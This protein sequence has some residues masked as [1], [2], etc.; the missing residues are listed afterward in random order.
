MSSSITEFSIDFVKLESGNVP[1]NKFLDTLSIIER[2]EVLALIEEFRILKSHN[3][4]L[5]QSMSKLLKEGIFEL[6]TKHKNRISRSL[7]FFTINK[8]IVFT[9]G[10]I[11]KTEKTP[12]N[13]IE[14]ALRYRNI[15]LK[16]KK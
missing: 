14:K 10:F 12:I 1:F 15:Y 8:V 5:P 6:R 4:N 7:Y 13:E 3:D 2:S 9:H 11:K 16:G